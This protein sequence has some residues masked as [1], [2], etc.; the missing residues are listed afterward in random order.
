MFSFQETAKLSS[1]VAVLLC[2][3]TTNEWKWLCLYWKWISCRQHLVDFFFILSVNLDLLIGKFRPLMFKVILDIAGWISSNNMFVSVFYLL[4]LFFDPFLSSLTS[5]LNWAFPSIMNVHQELEN[6]VLWAKFHLC[7]VSRL[8]FVQSHTIC[9]P[10]L[11]YYC[12]LLLS[13]TMAE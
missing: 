11:A 10:L 8:L 2:I 5:N 13:T 3:P 7:S 9:L 1:K 4:P 6:Y 12:L